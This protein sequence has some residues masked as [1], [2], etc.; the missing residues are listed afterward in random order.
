MRMAGQHFRSRMGVGT[1][2]S[3]TL[4]PRVADQPRVAQG[5]ALDSQVKVPLAPSGR[6]HLLGF[7]VCCPL[8]SRSS[9]SKVREEQCSHLT[10]SLLTFADLWR[11]GACPGSPHP[12]ASGWLPSHFRPGVPGADSGCSSSH[13]R[14]SLSRGHYQPDRSADPDPVF[15]HSGVPR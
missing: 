1:L 4:V 7:R 14:D 2:S 11:L 13:L 8:P 3:E 5:T 9:D 15:G 6:R 12:A 10:G